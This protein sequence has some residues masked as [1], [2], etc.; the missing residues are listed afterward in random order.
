MSTEYTFPH[1]TETHDHMLNKYCPLQKHKF[2]CQLLSWTQQK[3]TF[4]YP[5][6]SLHSTVTSNHMPSSVLFSKEK[7]YSHYHWILHS[8]VTHIHIPIAILHS[9][10]THIS[11]S[12]AVLH[13]TET[14]SHI[15]IAITAFYVNKLSHFPCYPALYKNTLSHAH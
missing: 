10:G 7:T 1:S 9:T 4:T 2:L 11:M 8:T 5:L 14:N 15:P 12:T 6:P 13:F 3:H